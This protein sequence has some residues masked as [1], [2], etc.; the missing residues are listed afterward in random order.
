MFFDQQIKIGVG[1][2]FPET[3]KLKSQGGKV[4]FEKPRLEKVEGFNFS[5]R[6]LSKKWKALTFPPRHLAVRVRGEKGGG[7]ALSVNVI[8]NPH[9]LG[10][11]TNACML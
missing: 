1:A 4:D 9:T 8:F 3:K 6:P 2:Q 11:G 10:S 5:T 7:G